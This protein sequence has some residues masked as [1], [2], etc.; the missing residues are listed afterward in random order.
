MENNSAKLFDSKSNNDNIVTFTYTPKMVFNNNNS[1]VIK[2]PLENTS[3]YSSEN[4]DE[5]LKMLLGKCWNKYECV[6]YNTAIN[7]Y[8]DEG[9]ISNSQY[10]YR[11]IRKDFGEFVSSTFINGMYIKYARDNK[12]VKSLLYVIS[13]VDTKDLFEKDFSI[14]TYSLL[15][16]D[17][18]IK[19]LALQCIE[20]WFDVKYVDF[21]KS[22]EIGVKYLD[23]YRLQI[24]NEIETKESVSKCI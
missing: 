21:L 23:E 20:K 14:I 22:I 7:E 15:N 24:I 17:F 13:E 6:F 19:D 16:R 3:G 9:Y 12:F 10:L 1:N 18:E 11:N 8:I 5:I 2:E 4:I